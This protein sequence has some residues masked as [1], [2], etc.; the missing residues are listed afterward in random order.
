MK[1]IRDTTGDLPVFFPSPRRFSDNKC[2]VDADG[3]TRPRGKLEGTSAACPK[4][5]ETDARVGPSV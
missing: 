2:Q 1:G 5:T 4:M 3:V